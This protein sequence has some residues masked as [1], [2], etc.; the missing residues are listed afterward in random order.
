MR[1]A[2]RQMPSWLICDVGQKMTAEDHTVVDCISQADDGSVTLTLVEPREWTNVPVMLADIEKKLSAYVAFVVRGGLSA[3]RELK[4]TEKVRIDLACQ[5][6]PP[7]SVQPL[8]EQALGF[9][10]SKKI[11]FTVSQY[12][13]KDVPPKRLF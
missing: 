12:L 10:T 11:D 4:P 9:T 7:D 1:H 2:A 3:Q 5:H 13:A 6:A 8:F